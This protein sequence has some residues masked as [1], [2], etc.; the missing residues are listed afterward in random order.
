MLYAITNIVYE[1]KQP[2]TIK[3]NQRCCVPPSWFFVYLHDDRISLGTKHV[4]LADRYQQIVLQLFNGFPKRTWPNLVGAWGKLYHSKHL[5]YSS[6]TKRKT[7]YLTMGTE[8]IF[9]PPKEKCTY[10]TIGT[11]Q[12]YPFTLLPPKEKHILNHRYLLPNK[13]TLLLIHSFTHLLFNP[14]KGKHIL[15]QRYWT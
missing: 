12:T 3:K 8:H 9:L 14:P 1:T 6:I 13:L 11:E 15:N 4:G 7:T 10:W 5:T 2:S